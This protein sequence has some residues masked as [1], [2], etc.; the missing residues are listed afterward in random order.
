MNIPEPINKLHE[1]QESLRGWHDMRA[2]TKEIISPR[3]GYIKRYYQRPPNSRKVTTPNQ[4]PSH[5]LCH[6]LATT[7]L[8]CSTF[9]LLI[10]YNL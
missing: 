4:R 5:R 2:R 3:S 7:H 8:L 1:L 10:G 9:I 6:Y